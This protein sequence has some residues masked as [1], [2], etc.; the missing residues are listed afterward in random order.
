MSEY[1]EATKVSLRPCRPIQLILGRPFFVPVIPA[2]K[3]ART[4]D[5]SSGSWLLPNVVM[6]VTMELLRHAGSKEGV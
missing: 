2:S 6:T 1:N 5:D 3:S 4:S